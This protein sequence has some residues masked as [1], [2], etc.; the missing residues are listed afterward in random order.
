MRKILI[1]G[2]IFCV[3]LVARGW[4]DVAQSRICEATGE[5]LSEEEFYSRV[6]RNRFPESNEIDIRI[7]TQT[8]KQGNV[9]VV[10]TDGVN[11]VTFHEGI[12]WGGLWGK[13]TWLSSGY[14]EIYIGG[15]QLITMDACGEN[16]K[17]YG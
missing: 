6:F 9:P 14:V 8:M 1:F 13:A 11:E 15:N 17:A 5:R 10:V 12:K 3:L 2:G 16:L 7:G 4:F